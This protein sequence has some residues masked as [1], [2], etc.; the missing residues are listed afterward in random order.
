MMTKMGS[1]KSSALIVVFALAIVCLSFNIELIESKVH[2][3]GSPKTLKPTKNKPSAANES[4]LA[5]PPGSGDCSKR[6]FCCFAERS[7][8]KE[9]S[10]KDSS[11]TRCKGFDFKCCDE[12][13]SS[14]DP[15]DTDSQ[16]LH[17]DGDLREDCCYQGQFA[18]LEEMAGTKANSPTECKG[19]NRR[20]CRALRTG[21]SP[22]S[23][24]I[25][26]V[27]ECFTQ[28]VENLSILKLELPRTCCRLPLMSGLP[29]C[30]N[31]SKLSA[32]KKP[33][34]VYY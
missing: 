15:D 2:P 5:S 7:G 19:F 28:L 17:C 20:C 33:V 8:G 14:E 16:P 27:I 24:V 21:V 6:E 25:S 9:K 10:P 13:N 11:Q 22:K 30:K 18:I 3:S 32:N 29:I 26:L 12:F 1:G 23:T 4:L 34:L 31:K